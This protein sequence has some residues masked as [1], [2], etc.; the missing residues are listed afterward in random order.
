MKLPRFYP[1]LD[2]GI[3]ERRGVECTAAAAE[4]LEG[5]VEILQFRHKGHLSRGVFSTAKAVGE[6]CWSAGALFVVDDRADVAAMLG[7][8]LHLGQEDL[9]PALA[10]RVTGGD[11]VIGFSTHNDAQMRAAAA[12]PVDYLAIGPIFATGSKEN[13]DPVV[14]REK[15]R[16]WRALTERPLVAI[17]GITRDN[18]V[19]VLEAGADSVAVIGDLYPEPLDLRTLRERIGEW[20]TLLTRK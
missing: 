1:I 8:G 14:G 17:G 2:T 15:L 18:A 12:E 10:R 7:A 13:P 4:M 19:S 9:P 11:Q 20:Q 5:G 3:L 6:L 16:E